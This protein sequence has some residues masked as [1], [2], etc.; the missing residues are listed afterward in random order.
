VDTVS[1]K[2]F[3]SRSRGERRVV[4]CPFAPARFFFL[5]AWVSAAMWR[6]DRAAAG[7]RLSSKLLVYHYLRAYPFVLFPP[8]HESDYYWKKSE[9]VAPLLV[10]DKPKPIGH[11]FG[12]A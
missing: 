4:I 9:R 10:L 8:E 12:R 7:V 6:L 5:L 1:N 11:S 2:I 3:I